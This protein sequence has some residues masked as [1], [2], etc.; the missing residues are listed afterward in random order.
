MVRVV[1]RLDPYMEHMDGYVELVEDDST[2]VCDPATLV[3]SKV[4]SDPHQLVPP[5]LLWYI[6]HHPKEADVPAATVREQPSLCHSKVIEMCARS[7]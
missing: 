7:G 5:E 1:A 6:G 3:L 4:L 2:F